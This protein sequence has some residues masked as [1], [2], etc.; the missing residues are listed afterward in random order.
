MKRWTNFLITGFVLGL[1]L[2]TKWWAVVFLRPIHNIEIIP[3]LVDLSY[4]ENSGI[5]FGLFDK[6]ESTLKPV[7]LFIL[8]GLAM[9]AVLHYMFQNSSGQ[10]LLQVSL[11]ILLGGIAGNFIDRIFHGTVVDFVDLHW[12]DLYHWPTFNVADAAITAGVFLIL[13]ETFLL[14]RNRKTEER[15]GA[16][17]ESR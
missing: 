6:S 17:T 16:T 5:A 15:A 2:L 12:K 10:R 14:E 7:L 9:L 8:A 1:D 11:S 3:G 13:V 4:A